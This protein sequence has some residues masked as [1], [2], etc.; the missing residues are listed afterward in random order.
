MVLQTKYFFVD[1][2]RSSI[3]YGTKFLRVLIFA[4]FSSDRQKLVPANRAKL[5]QTFFSAK[6]YSGVNIFSNLNLLHRNI[7][8]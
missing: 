5:P 6:M 8:N 3:P 2:S 7:V 4:I 1:T